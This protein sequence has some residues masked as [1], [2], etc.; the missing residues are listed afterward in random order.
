MDTAKSI[1]I[2]TRKQ[3]TP[4]MLDP[5]IDKIWV[6]YIADKSNKEFRDKL[7]IQYIYLVKYVVGRLRMT[8]PSSITTED[9]SSY[10]VEGLIDA[11]KR[12]VPS[13]GVRFET[14]ALMRIRGSIIDQLRELDWMPKGTRRRL[15]KV[16]KAMLNLQIKLERTPT[17]E[18]V[19][20]E[21]NIS[22]ERVQM[23]IAEIE[24]NT[25]ISIYDNSKD[26]VFDGLAIIDTIQ[27]GTLNPLD[28]LETIDVKKDLSLALT[29]LPERERMILALYYHENM[30]LKE[31]G[32]AIS[33]SESRVCQ[34]HA[35]AIM[36]LRKLL[37]SRSSRK[38]II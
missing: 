26:T 4:K 22:K 15:K 31:I 36:R 35:Q 17:N 34:L 30:T 1:K 6:Q 38:R 29:R 37:N 3:K 33:I 16:Q 18:E 23:A 14:Y 32:E 20:E 21:L 9:I 5:E 7:I 13:K 27:D 11:I 10:G 25:I 19:A 28:E 2:E 24:N 12:F 8:L